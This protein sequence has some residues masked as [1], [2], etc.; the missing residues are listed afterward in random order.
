MDFQKDFLLSDGKRLALA[1]PHTKHC[2]LL[3]DYHITSVE[4]IDDRIVDVFAY[5]DR[6]PHQIC[7]GQPVLNAQIS[8]RG[9]EVVPLDEAQKIMRSANSMSIEE[10]MCVVYQKMDQRE[11]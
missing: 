9:F 8:S 2:F 5:S 6:Y 4:V 11:S 3:Q 7:A 1:W 10:L